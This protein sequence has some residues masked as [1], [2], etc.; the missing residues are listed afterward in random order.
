MTGL[1]GTNSLDLPASKSAA[2]TKPSWTARLIA[3][4]TSLTVVTFR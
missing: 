4:V 3:D 2:R 1:T